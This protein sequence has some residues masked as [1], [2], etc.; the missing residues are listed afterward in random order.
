MQSKNRMKKTVCEDLYL[1][2]QF[3]RAVESQL[4]STYVIL[5]VIN[6]M[7]VTGEKYFYKWL[8]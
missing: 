7:K 8:F 3:E 1:K 4:L 6:H 2:V 5:E